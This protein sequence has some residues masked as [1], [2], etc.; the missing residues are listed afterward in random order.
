MLITWVTHDFN[1][2]GE[3]CEENYIFTS[4]TRPGITH[5]KAMTEMREE[6]WMITQDFHCY[7]PKCKI[8]KRKYGK[9]SWR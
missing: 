7:C 2:D 3:G 6:G 9:K 4:D 5:R 8:G 1:C